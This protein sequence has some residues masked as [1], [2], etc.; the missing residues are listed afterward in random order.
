MS[1]HQKI[2]GMEVDLLNSTNHC[3]TTTSVFLLAREFVE[4]SGM[5]MM[6]DTGI[7]WI[8]HRYAAALLI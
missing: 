8:L 3:R 5:V 1:F 7:H 4:I 6:M 2:T